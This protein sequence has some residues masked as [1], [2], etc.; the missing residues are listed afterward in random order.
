MKVWSAGGRRAPK[1]LSPFQP[2][3]PMSLLDR[4]FAAVAKTNR[5]SVSAF[6]RVSAL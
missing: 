3:K 5:D 6:H 1:E 2:K 4:G